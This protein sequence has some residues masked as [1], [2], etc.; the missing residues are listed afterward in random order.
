MHP[1]TAT[2]GHRGDQYRSGPTWKPTAGTSPC[3]GASPV[4]FLHN[5]PFYASRF[6]CIDDPV[7]YGLLP[8]ISRQV[9]T[10]GIADDADYRIT[11]IQR[12]GL[13]TQCL[14]CNRWVTPSRCFINLNMPGTHN[15]L[16]ATAAVVVA[17]DEGLP[18]A[19]MQ[20]G[21]AGLPVSAGVLPGSVNSTFPAARQNW[22]MT[23]ATTPP[24][25][26]RRWN[27]FARL[28]RRAAW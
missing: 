5:L 7:V 21:L 18:D 2:D 27:R 25:C 26:V 28:G 14:S 17:C 9:I 15:V 4:E 10:Y 6:W 20:R 13:S 11:N 3:C 1:L 19:A 22:S 12:N 8:D 16:N 24:R 23:T